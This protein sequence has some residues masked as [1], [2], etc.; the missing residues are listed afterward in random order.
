MVTVTNGYSLSDEISSSASSIAD[1]GQDI[2]DKASK[3]T[4]S[5]VE[6]GSSKVNDLKNSVSS[7]AL[8]AGGN[9]AIKPPEW[10]D[11]SGLSAGQ[12][13][14]WF[15]DTMRDMLA[16]G[17]PGGYGGAGPDHAPISKGVSDVPEL[18]IPAEL[19]K[20]LW[21]VVSQGSNLVFVSI[22]ELFGNLAQGVMQLFGFKNIGHQS[23]VEQGE[24]LP[25]EFQ[26]KMQKMMDATWVGKTRMIRNQD[27]AL[28]DGVFYR[29]Y[30]PAIERM[31]NIL[32]I[33]LAVIL[34]VD[35]VALG[36]VAIQKTLSRIRSMG[37]NN[38]R[39]I[40][41][42]FKKAL[43]G[44]KDDPDGLDLKDFK[45]TKEVTKSKVLG[46]DGLPVTKGE[47]AIWVRN[48]KSGKIDHPPVEAKA[49][50][51][52]R[53]LKNSS[54]KEIL[55]LATKLGVK[56]LKTGGSAVAWY[57]GLKYSISLLLKNIQ[58]GESEKL[59]DEEIESLASWYAFSVIF[60]K[61]GGDFVQA[62]RN[63]W[64]RMS[65]NTKIRLGQAKPKSTAPEAGFL[66][67]AV[68]SEF[69]QY[70]V[71]VSAG[72][73]SGTIADFVRW[74]ATGQ[75]ESAYGSNTESDS[76]ISTEEQEPTNLKQHFNR[77]GL[78]SGKPQ[79]RNMRGGGLIVM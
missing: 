9:K 35:E 42:N 32:G 67:S 15:W 62:I 2:Y 79:V 63:G 54:K 69:I 41:D 58:P 28:V 19:V 72:G 13:I 56:G 12:A 64:K 26:A 5:L 43:K 38:I 4:N 47:T 16:T 49:G 68:I 71:F 75:D 66:M 45:T 27:V 76:L 22:D 73:G 18:N 25:P 24:P 39:A 46:P 36:G 52:L 14:D 60:S 44:K 29:A 40:Y 65:H 17:G 37:G 51:A 70:V 7:D 61:K 8:T 53:K 55:E 59:T 20:R 30:D 48:V 3:A 11:L 23:D 77:G 31:L 10:V 1:T 33:A 34:P 6:A 50:A 78:I 21:R 74:V 57:F